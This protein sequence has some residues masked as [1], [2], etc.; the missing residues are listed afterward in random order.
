M[1][2]KN[3]FLHGD[4]KEEVASSAWFKFFIQENFLAYGVLSMV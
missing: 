3:A 1:D 2:F 4:L